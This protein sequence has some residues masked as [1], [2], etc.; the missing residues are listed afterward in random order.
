MIVL[1]SVNA[2]KQFYC[3]SNDEGRRLDRVIKKMLPGLP[4]GLIYSSLRKGRIK[5]NGCKVKQ[6][7][8][9]G[10]GD[11]IEV[12]ES[13]FYEIP[14]SKLPKINPVEASAELQKMT[15][16][17]TKNLL[18]MN[19]PS[20]MLTHGDNSLA[21]LL[22]VGLFDIEDS[23]SFTPSPLHRLDR[24]TSGLIIA[25]TTIRGAAHFSQLMRD[26]KIRKYYLGLCLGGPKTDIV[27]QDRLIRRNNKSR[28]SVSPEAGET[29]AVTRVFPLLSENRYVL[30]LFRIDTGQTHQI[31]SQLSSAGFPLAGDVK[32]GGDAPGFRSYILH[33]FSMQ[34]DESDE[35]CG[36]QS[37]RAE[38]PC[39]SRTILYKLLGESKVISALNNIEYF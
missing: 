12:H 14:D 8:N 19:K 28:T 9:T 35:I 3:K 2:Y 22:K 1:Q 6:S 38:L 16:L 7:Y 24:N 26:K 4:A 18:L 29:A 17:R 13:I 5:V 36:F 34:L 10:P 33:S 21:Q 15:V 11:V 23:L 27:L 39:P 25:G 32:Y 37:V 31:R 20:G 30:C